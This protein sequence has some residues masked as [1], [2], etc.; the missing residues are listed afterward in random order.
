MHVAWAKAYLA[1]LMTACGQNEVARDHAQEALRLARR[2]D[3]P[4]VEV[5]G[6]QMLGRAQPRLAKAR[7]FFD[8]GLSL[9][10]EHS[11]R[12]QSASIRSEL[13]WVLSEMG[14]QDEGAALLEQANRARSDMG[15]T[16]IEIPGL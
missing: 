12:P 5:M 16:V 11:L 4:A 7:A 9:A 14:E 1:E 3:L 15:L 6:L 13:A 10:G 8:E 2:H